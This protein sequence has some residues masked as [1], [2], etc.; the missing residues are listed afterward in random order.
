MPRP[1]L[2]ILLVLEQTSVH[3]PVLVLIL[4]AVGGLR[5][6][7]GQRVHPLQGHVQGHVAK[8]AGLDVFL[9]DL[10]GRLTD[11][12]GAVRSLIVRELDQGQLGR[13]LANDRIVTQVED[14]ALDVRGR[15]ALRL[16]SCLQ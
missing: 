2:E 10:R 9:G 6:L 13:G 15:G 11:V 8:L 4:G 14:L 1:G 5:G 3:L 16:W 7:E 12:P